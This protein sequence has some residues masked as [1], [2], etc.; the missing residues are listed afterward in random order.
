[1][2]RLRTLPKAVDEFKKEDPGTCVTLS[3]LRRWVKEGKVVPV[4]SGTTAL[5]DVDAVEAFV[6]GGGAAC[7]DR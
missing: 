1:M 3:R 2:P 7:A 4:Y 6:S 5:V